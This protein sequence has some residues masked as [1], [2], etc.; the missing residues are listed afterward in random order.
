MQLAESE[1]VALLKARARAG[2]SV[3]LAPETALRLAAAL[4]AVVG[5]DR[6]PPKRQQAGEELCFS[7]DTWSPDGN[8]L[9][10]T[11]ARSKNLLIARAAF[12]ESTRQRPSY[13]VT[14]RDG[15]CSRS[16]GRRKR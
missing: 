14:L 4:E 13:R 12:E 7:I 5:G 15:A 10:E 11:M 3:R 1:L 2:R 6:R 8:K 16:S 9:W